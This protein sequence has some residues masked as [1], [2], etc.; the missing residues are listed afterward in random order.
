MPRIYKLSRTGLKILYKIRHH[1]GHGI[2]SPFVYNLVRKVIEEKT[3]YYSYQDLKDY[4]YNQPEI[5]GKIDKYNRLSFRLVNYFGAKR[6]LEIGSGKGINTLYLTAPSK[7]IVCTSVETNTEKQ[8]VAQKLYSGWDRKIHLVEGKI[9]PDME[10]KQ[11]CIFIDLDSYKDFG[12]DIVPYLSSMLHENTF[13][14]VR[15]IRTNRRCRML[16]KSISDMEARTAMLDLFNIGIIFFNKKLY[17]W[18]YQ[19]SY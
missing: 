9:L 5:K 8:A 6:I 3:P 19:I 7:D 13:I 2:H 14:V 10:K 1:R 17:R 11:D 4:I 12:K 15:G 18:N 16:W